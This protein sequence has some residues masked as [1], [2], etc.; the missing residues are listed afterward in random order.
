MLLQRGL[1]E[2][3]LAWLRRIPD[4]ATPAFM[5]NV[6]GWLAQSSYAAVRALA[7]E[8]AWQEGTA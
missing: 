8:T 1:P 2:Q 7:D 5:H 6:R 4:A 3:A